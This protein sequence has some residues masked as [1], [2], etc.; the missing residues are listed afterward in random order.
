M[1]CHISALCIALPRPKSGLV[2]TTLGNSWRSA[3]PPCPFRAPAAPQPP[4]PPCG[5]RVGTPFKGGDTLHITVLFKEEEFSTHRSSGLCF[6]DRQR[7][8]AEF[9]CRR[10]VSIQ[11]LGPLSRIQARRSED[12]AL[13]HLWSSLRMALRVLVP[14]HLRKAVHG[15]P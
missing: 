2:E 13:W 9:C 12:A 6:R 7:V 14:T 3:H 15:S 11:W 4:P 10:S 5:G 8:R 1:S